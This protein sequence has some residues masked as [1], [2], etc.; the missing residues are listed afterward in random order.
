MKSKNENSSYFFINPIDDIEDI[1]SSY[2]L[3]YSR[4]N[5]NELI[6][7]YKGLWNFYDISFCWMQSRDL[8]RINNKLNIK[9]PNKLKKKIQYMLTIIN[10]KILLGYFGFSSEFNCIF[11]RHNVS[12]RG[13][14][15]FSSEQIEDF[16]DI[17]IN[18]CDKYFPAFHIFLH[19]KNDPH[20]ALKTALLET[21]GEA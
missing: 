12:M 13:A 20:F 19:K 16:I 11:Y 9:I 8:I 3:E 10:E 6:L 7:N 5:K 21:V 1:V 18:E 2:E 17:V 15:K 14:G 4:N